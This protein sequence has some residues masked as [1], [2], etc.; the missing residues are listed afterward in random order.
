MSLQIATSRHMGDIR[1][2]CTRGDTWVG[3][4]C[5][6][7]GC[8][9]EK[10][11]PAS[12]HSR[13]WLAYTLMIKICTASSW[14]CRLCGISNSQ[15]SLNT[16]IS[17][18]LSSTLFCF[19]KRAVSLGCSCLMSQLHPLEVTLIK[20]AA[21]PHCLWNNEIKPLHSKVYFVLPCSFSCFV[22]KANLVKWTILFCFLII[23]IGICSCLIIMTKPV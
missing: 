1:G 7:S 4:F 19:K 17:C 5:R 23:S 6:S 22:F 9:C 8:L 20:M 2:W 10:P 11:Y 13:L 14:F 16:G 12:V 15:S 21:L 18:A 3:R